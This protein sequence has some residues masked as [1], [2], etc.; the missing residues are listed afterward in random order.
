MRLRHILS[1]KPVPRPLVTVAATDTVGTVIDQLCRHRI[2]SLPVVDAES[3]E[4]VGI[5]CERDVLYNCCRRCAEGHQLAVSTIMTRDV[6]TAH[7]DE[8]VHTALERMSRHNI[9]HLPLLDS[10]RLVGIVSIND[11]LRELYQAD[12]TKLRGLSDF[13]AGTYGSRVF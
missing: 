12:E 11:I 2:G 1:S 13:F 6:V 5:V 4:L 7:P 9:R 3:G 10:G 8:D